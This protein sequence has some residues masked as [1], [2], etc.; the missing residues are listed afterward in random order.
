MQGGNA[1]DP[2]RGWRRRVILAVAACSL[3]AGVGISRLRMDDDLRSL[4]RNSDAEFVAIDEIAARFG[5]PDRDCIVRAEAREGTLFDPLTLDRFRALA[6]AVREVD[7]VEQVRS[8]LDVRRQG[9]AGP[10]ASSA[11]C[12]RINWQQS[13]THTHS[14]RRY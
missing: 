5:A 8:M 11:Q 10:P 2:A 13:A 3:L 14:L 9:A 4:L 6:A 7:G 12:I 1:V